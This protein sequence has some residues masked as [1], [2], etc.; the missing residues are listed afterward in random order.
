MSTKFALA[1]LRTSNGYRAA[2]QVAGKFYKLGNTG[3][4]QDYPADTT[5]MDLLQ[6][7]PTAMPRLSSIASGIEHNKGTTAAVDLAAAGVSTDT[8]IRFPR[9]L[10]CVGANYGGHLREMGLPA[11]KMMPMPYFLRPPTTSLVGPGQTVRKPRMTKE[12]DWEI[13]VVIVLGRPLRNCETLEEAADAIAG[14][15]VGLDLS[16]RDLQTA[17]DI[18]MDVGR[19]KAQDTLAP[20]GPVMVPKQSLPDGIGDLSLKLWVNGE[21][22]VDGST[23]DML[24]SPEEQLQELSKF[25]TLERVTWWL[26]IGD[27][28][29]AEIESIGVLEVVIREDD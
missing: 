1:T 14:Y 19:G 4:G 12:F 17:K 24:Y 21:Q 8:P 15:T 29:T 5:M 18:G 7:W 6:D 11:E 27:R 3:N 28:V 20:C 26:Q 10:I 25:M 16:C 22:M 2:M 9:K 23:K 13:E